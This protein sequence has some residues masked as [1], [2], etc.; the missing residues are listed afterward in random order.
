MVCRWG[1]EDLK[2]EPRHR[3][4][5][6]GFLEVNVRSRSPGQQPHDL[7]YLRHLEPRQLA[8]PGVTHS[9]DGPSPQ[10]LPRAFLVQRHEYAIAGLAHIELHV[11]RTYRER[12]LVRLIGPAG[13]VL[14]AAVVRRDGRTMAG[15]T[16]HA[17]MIVD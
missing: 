11:V 10:A 16:G 7:R 4:R 13:A 6:P 12:I 14:A 17:T 3:D 8:Q 15:I 2:A 1:P 5:A 9:C